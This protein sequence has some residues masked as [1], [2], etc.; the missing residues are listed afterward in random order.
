MI[1]PRGWLCCEESDRRDRSSGRGEELPPRWVIAAPGS[2]PAMPG[3]MLA[4]ARADRHALQ[5]HGALGWIAREM[6]RFV[7]RAHGTGTR[8]PL[9][10]D[11]RAPHRPSQQRDLAHQ[12]E[13]PAQRT[14]VATPET[15]AHQ[16][17]RQDASE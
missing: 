15:I 4:A 12:A 3:E 6:A 11:A 2:R 7:N 13:Q 1:P 17:E 14:Q 10:F 8:T 5:T 16:V 9:T